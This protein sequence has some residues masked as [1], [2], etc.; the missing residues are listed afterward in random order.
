M[1][2]SENAATPAPESP[3]PV[4]VAGHGGL[5]VLNAPRAYPRLP[6]QER[7]LKGVEY[8]GIKKG[9]TKAELMDK[10]KNCLPQYFKERKEGAGEA[11]KASEGEAK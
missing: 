11:P 2:T 4:M 1:D 7:F 5:I 9:I 10:M 6:Q 3:P 8:C